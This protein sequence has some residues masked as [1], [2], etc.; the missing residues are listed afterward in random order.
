MSAEN[1]ELVRRL[2]EAVAARDS[3][4]VLSIYHR[5]LVWDHSHN[6]EMVGLTA[7]Q[8]RTYH[9]HDGLRRWARD[10]YEV[11]ENVQAELE[12]VVDLGEE[13]VLVLLNYRGRGR[14]SGIEVAFI[15][16]AGIFMIRDGQVVRVD[17]YRDKADA[18]EDAG[19]TE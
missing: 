7:G 12:E 17:W 2:Y 16:L 6:S 11:F 15:Q 5:D 18:L 3:E 13:R 8:S 1:V 10:F 19:L 14:V 9:G 4:A